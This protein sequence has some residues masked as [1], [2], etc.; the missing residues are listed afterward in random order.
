MVV[1]CVCSLCVVRCVLFV[2]LR[3]VCLLLSRLVAGWLLFVGCC[4]LRVA[5]VVVCGVCW[6]PFRLSR[7]VSCVVDWLLFVVCC[8][9]VVQCLLFVVRCVLFI[10]CCSLIVAVCG[11][12]LYVV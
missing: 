7:C 11:L 8:V 3:V 5:V 12:L 1:V 4:L 10:A 2:A 6:E 9:F